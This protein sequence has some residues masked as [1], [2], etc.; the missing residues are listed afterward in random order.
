MVTG[1]HTSDTMGHEPGCGLCAAIHEEQAH[2]DLDAR[3]QRQTL[4]G[5]KASTVTL[6][7]QVDTPGAAPISLVKSI[8][9]PAG[10]RFEPGAV[11]I[12]ASGLAYEALKA[13]GGR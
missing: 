10:G 4:S 9:V 3:R 8:T 13:R 2:R 1:H 12:A 11:A 6:A 5:D 7:L